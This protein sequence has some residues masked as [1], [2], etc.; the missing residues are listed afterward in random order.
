MISLITHAFSQMSAKLIHRW[1]QDLLWYCL[2][3]WENSFLVFVLGRA[4][5]SN[6]CCL[7]YALHMHFSWFWRSFVKLTSA[8]C[9]PIPTILSFYWS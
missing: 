9:G 7:N 4:W 3:L 8:V 5:T 1:L 2:G 6:S